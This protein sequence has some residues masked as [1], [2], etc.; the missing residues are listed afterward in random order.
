MMLYYNLQNNIHRNYLSR[1]NKYLEVLAA[2]YTSM[3]E[4]KTGKSHNRRVRFG[5][6]KEVAK[7]HYPLL[8]YYLFSCR[9]KLTTEKLDLQ[10]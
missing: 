9:E 3:A 1:G 8:P 10:V 7:F 4:F 2:K 5:Y 6:A